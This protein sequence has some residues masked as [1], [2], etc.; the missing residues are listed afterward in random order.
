MN[1]KK[2]KEDL[3]Y[4]L[5]LLLGPLQDFV[6]NPERYNPDSRSRTAAKY[7]ADDPRFE[8]E[9]REFCYSE[10]GHV[11][12]REWRKLHNALHRLRCAVEEHLDE[13]EVL[14]DLME[15]KRRL[16]RDELMSIPVPTD[17]QILEAYTP[18]STYCCL[19]ELCQ[20]VSG[21]LI[22]VDRYLDSSVFYRY[23]RDVST[24]VKVVLLTWPD[25]KR[26]VREFSEFMDISRLYAVE[27]SHD[28][29]RLVVHEGFHDRWLCCDGQIYGLGGS[30]RDAGH[31]SDLTLT[32]VDPPDE[33]LKRIIQLISEGTEL[34]GP[35]QNTHP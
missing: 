13:P 15:E 32:K 17:A 4:K 18:F 19:K 21:E 8:M 24:D 31:K 27:R 6:D 7:F 30:F 26:N 11:Y 28:K 20:T 3:I 1:R 23:L 9:L 25:T 2:Q 22:L 35:S 16:I 34:F 5:G 33:G 12:H 10:P 14:K 29:Y